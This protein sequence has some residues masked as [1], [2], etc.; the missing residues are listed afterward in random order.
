ME[1]I[2][3]PEA[4]VDERS[5]ELIHEFM[6]HFKTYVEIDPGAVDRKGEVFESWA[7]QKIA[8]LQLAI[9]HLLRN[10]P[11]ARNGDPDDRDLPF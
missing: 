11:Q 4:E 1:W 2:G 5:E 6:N 7:I 10:L 9:E 8:G 3:A